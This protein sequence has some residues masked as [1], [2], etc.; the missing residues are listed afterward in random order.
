MTGA[1]SQGS[2]ASI[3]QLRERSLHAALKEWC[4]HPGDRLEANIDGY[5]IDVVRGDLLIEVQTRNIAGIRTKLL[6][7]AEQHDVRIVYPLVASRTIETV[8]ADG[9]TVLRRRRSP[10]KQVWASLFDELVHCPTLLELP[11][12]DLLAVR[13][14]VSEVRCADGL[15]SWRRQG[16][17]IRDTRLDTVLEERVFTG[18]HD[19][20]ALLPDSLEGA[21]T[22]RQLAAALGVRLATA[23]RASYCLRQLGLLRAAGSSGRAMLVERVT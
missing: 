20:I 23:Q 6:A 1:V 22:H 9:E 4:A 18:G 17:S 21:F 12:L 19:L 7:L 16:I 8:A 10:S 11:R 15:G 3:G 13:V 2:A 14:A 5:V